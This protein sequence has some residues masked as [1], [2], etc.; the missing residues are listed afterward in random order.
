MF[1]LNGEVIFT[2]WEGIMSKAIK[3]ALLSGL[4]FPG[5]GQIFLQR[6]MRG[7]IIMG[8]AAAGLVITVAVV[9]HR[10]IAILSQLDMPGGVIDIQT[11]SKLAVQASSSNTGIYRGALLLV[12]CCWMF[13][14][15][16]AY[17]L[18]KRHHLKR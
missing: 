18:G 6:Y 15:I 12:V 1:D 3:A 8:S 11:I 10:A 4:V 7:I 5:T 14:T 13:S 17:R 9:I 2:V 16:D